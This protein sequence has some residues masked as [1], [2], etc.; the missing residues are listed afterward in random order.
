M[1]GLALPNLPIGEANHEYRRLD[2]TRL[3]VSVIGVGT[4]QVG[5]EWGRRFTQHEVDD[6]LGRARTL[7]A[8]LL[9]T[10]EC[11]GDHLAEALIGTAIRH[12]RKDWVVATRFGPQF[13]PKPERCQRARSRANDG[14]SRER[15]TCWEENR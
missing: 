13:T 14:S 3:R 6:L 12:H 2:K 1:R 5:G 4:W 15:I 8:N 10:A 7:G 11:Y 9:D